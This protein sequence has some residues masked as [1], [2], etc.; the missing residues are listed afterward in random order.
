MAPNAMIMIDKDGVIE[1]V[2][3]QAEKIFGYA[4]ADLIGKSIDI[5]LP[6]RYRGSHPHHRKAFFANSSPR[7]MGVGR[8]L[9]GR[10]KDGSEFPVEIGLNPIQTADGIKVLSAIVDIS[11]RKLQEE[12]FRQV[13]EMA[14]NSMIMIDKEGIIE[15][16][17]VQT[18]KI[19][20]YARAELIG[21]S[22]DILLPDRF[23]GQH[24]DHRRTFFTTPKPR[25]MGAGRELF[26]RRKDG[27]E[28]PLEIGLNPIMTA[29]GM[30]V[31][32]AIVDIS[33]RKQADLRQQKLIGELTR[34]NEELNNFAYVSSHDLKSPLRGIDQLATWIADDLRE[35]LNDDTKNHL[36]LMR[37]RIKRMNTLLDDLLAYSKVGR[38]NGDI[39]TVNTTDLIKDIFDLTATKKNIQ[40]ELAN[41][42]PTLLT[43]KVPL[44]LV[45]RNLIGN[46][47]KHHDK[48]HGNIKIDALFLKE[49]VEFSVAD[50]GP[51]IPLEHQQRVFAMFQTL[52]PRDEV[53]GSGIGLSLVKKTIEAEGGQITLESDGEHGS[54]FRFI[55]PNQHK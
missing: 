3:V 45:F 23:R 51:G 10:H 43:R 19:F 11:E 2:N 21:Q 8:E 35:T 34:I 46:A 4:R 54:T 15:L 29:S 14:P 12:Q 17:N 48:D 9:F 42:L 40:L 39:V 37:S 33:D 47:I 30:K 44:E 1:L 6:E 31:L 38:S 25:A 49:G 26:G 16:I 27:S 52:K 13:V 41:E 22:I 24:P 28:F 50:D 32:S 5:L 55:W 7:S 36:Q 53:E 18:E 20:G